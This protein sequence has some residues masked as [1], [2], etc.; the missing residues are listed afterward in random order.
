M[1]DTSERIA[2]MHRRTRE[3]R[4]K[5]EGTTL[6]MS[7]GGCMALFV[8]LLGFVMNFGGGTLATGTYTGTMLLSENVGGYVL[9]AVMAFMAGVAV[10][11][12]LRER[13]RAKSKRQ[14]KENQNEE[15]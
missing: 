10:T 4:H 5:R 14:V 9:V 12:F 8:A 11:V 15:G 2:S 1:R 6:I 7:G 13:T 3:L